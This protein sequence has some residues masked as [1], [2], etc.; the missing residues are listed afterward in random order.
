MV[1]PRIL[2]Q[3]IP[4]GDDVAKAAGEHEEMEDGVHESAFVET[5]E[6]GTGYVA[7]AFGDNPDDGRRAHGV[8]ERAE[9]DEDRQ[10]HSHE[11]G[12]LHVAVVFEP[13]EADDGSGDGREPYEREETPAPIALLAQGDERQRRVAAGDVPVD[14]GVVP[15]AQAFL[16]RTPARH[17][18]IEGRCGVGAEHAEEIER[19]PEAGPRIVT[20]GADDEEDD[21]DDDAHDDARG[22][23]PGVQ[24]FFAFG[25]SYCHNAAKVNINPENRLPGGQR[26][27]L[28]R[29]W[30][31]RKGGCR[32]RS[33]MASLGWR[34]RKEG[35]AKP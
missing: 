34:K 4:D 10:A 18:M 23:G 17:G 13:A 1:S 29:S 32:L 28:F 21:A 31:V 11:T 20:A 35:V 25:I 8:D 7:D 6:D 16:P 33:R 5:V 26:M 19:D 14:G 27:D 22:V 3:H 9:S 2:Q 30:N 12:G 15:A 24:L